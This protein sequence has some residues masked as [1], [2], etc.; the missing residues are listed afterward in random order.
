MKKFLIG[1]AAV[2]AI[3]VVAVIA[4]SLYFVS[5]F[6]NA[7]PDSDHLKAVRTELVD[8][9]GERDDYTPELDGSL[10][11][12][13]IALFMEVREDLILTRVEIASGLDEF[14]EMMQEDEGRTRNPF[15]KLVAGF[16]MVKGGAGLVTQGLTYLGA[17]SERLLEVGMGEG[18]Y[19]HYYTLMAFSWLEWDP[20]DQ[21]EPTVID[22]FDLESD[23]E[24]MVDEYR[25]IFQ[26]Q[27]RNQRNEL[28]AIENRTAAQDRAL[29]QVELGLSGEGGRFPF[30][31]QV[32]TEWLTLF[33]PY[34]YRFVDTLPKTAAEMLLDAI[35]L[36]DEDSGDGTIEI[37]FDAP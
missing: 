19:F 12:N 20:L 18:E 3:V 33:E 4:V 32:P 26:R 35:S 14:L 13:R 23:V 36:L 6:K 27:L 5:W 24:E 11:S 22:E 21:L 34:E 10:D 7:S 9:Y 30:Q 1:C 8:T 29:E 31:G 16:Q 15:Q 17:R 28:Q 37:N 2:S 25:R